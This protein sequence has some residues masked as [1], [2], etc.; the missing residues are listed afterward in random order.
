M[1]QV[2]KVRFS[3]LIIFILAVVLAV[4]D[5]PVIYNQSI[6]W[7]NNKTGQN[8][9]KMNE[10]SFHL[11]LDLQ[12]GTHLVYSADV[13]KVE[14]NK[15]EAVE[16]VR[17]VIERRVNAFGVSEPVV[18][19]NKA[20]GEY[21]VI[22]ELAG[23]SDVNEAISMIGETPLLEFKEQNNEPPR[24]LTAEEK[25]QLND[26]N[27]EARK[28]ADE[29]LQLVIKDDT[30]FN[31]IVQQY[32]EN[33][34]DKE[35]GGDM[36]WVSKNS[37]NAIVYNAVSEA[38]IEN[39]E[40][41]TEVI[42]DNEGL[43]IV[44]L[45]DQ[46]S[47]QKEVEAAHILIC[48]DGA[49]GCTQE[50][51]QDEALNKINEL[52]EQ[53]STENFEDLAKENSTEPGA[54][55]SGGSLGWFTKDAMVEPF[56]NVVFDMEIDTIS[57][58]VE[59]QF[60]YH[61]IHKTGERDYTEYK[62][63][64]VF[65]PLKTETDI[66]P[67]QEPFVNTGLTGG[68]LASAQVEFDPNTNMA[69]VGL[70]FDDEGKKLFAE[71]TERNIGQPV[72]I[73]LDK[74]PISVPRVNEKISGGQAVITGDFTVT[75]AKKLSMRLNA[76]AL[77]VPINLISQQTVGASLGQESLQKSLLAGMIGLI[78][79]ALF[80]MIFY[81]IPGILAV[82]SLAIYGIIVLFLFKM[83]PVTLT[84]SGIAG[85]ILSIGMAVDANV[86]IFERLK[87]ELKMGKPTGTAIEE[88]FKRAWN[89]IRDG[90]VSTLITCFI[91][92]W[93][94]TSMIQGFAITLGIGVMISMFSAVVV[95]RL[96]LQI[97]FAGKSDLK[98]K[99]LLGVNK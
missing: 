48:W 49:T 82:I 64:Q 38:G 28:K 50:I 17:D 43:H 2:T 12:G 41:L 24:D 62:L 59:T 96:L 46:R 61:L 95:T 84:L 14:D 80:M 1:K 47:D 8:I 63:S 31:N 74:Q 11:G 86:L 26:F 19:V 27:T 53:V 51:S 90:N 66:L 55:Q 67:P 5:F 57:D 13:S 21:R 15:G 30:D 71:I 83:I 72:A 88:S 6:D 73:Y 60:G 33:E 34:I 4:F 93:F 25:Q 23:I 44:K 65:F 18:Q 69:Q 45:N 70:K 36:G 39:G 52:K 92:T 20:Q 35:T 79:V 77:P 85:F 29:V 32:A 89:S 56:S 91:L 9:S 75:E 40:V 10:N 94:G 22:V 97:V 76:G 54:D 7:L 81:R 99:W 37:E 58:V 68:Q 3:F 98:Y 42:E 78:L 16:G 87:E